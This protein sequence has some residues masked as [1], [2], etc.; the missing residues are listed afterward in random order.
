MRLTPVV[1]RGC[2]KSTISSWTRPC[3][4]ERARFH[5][6]KT[7]AIGEADAH[8]ATG[9][10]CGNSAQ[11]PFPEFEGDRFDN[12]AAGLARGVPWTTTTLSKGNLVGGR[13]TLNGLKES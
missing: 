2:A 10:S 6:T 3:V 12:C 11:S 7:T 1:G 4:S 9:P 8:K 13:E 5:R